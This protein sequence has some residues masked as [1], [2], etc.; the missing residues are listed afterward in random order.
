MQ[1]P[2]MKL[3]PT[4][5]CLLHL[6]LFTTQFITTQMLKALS[7]VSVD[8]SLLRVPPWRNPWLLA[9]VTLPTLLHFAVL[10]TPGAT[11]VFGLAPLHLV[12]V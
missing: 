2:H 9:G 5:S 11:K 3:A 12:R 8:N 10:Y 1:A 4:Y 7:A 6:L